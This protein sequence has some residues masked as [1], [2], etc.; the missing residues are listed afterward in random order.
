MNGESGKVLLNIA[1]NTVGWRF[2]LALC[3]R[4][5]SDTSVVPCP[6]L[7][8]DPV[9]TSATFMQGPLHFFFFTY[10]FFLYAKDFIVIQHCK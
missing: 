8:L 5:T 2:R 6:N 9:F 4:D 3:E 10:V 7:F 1:L